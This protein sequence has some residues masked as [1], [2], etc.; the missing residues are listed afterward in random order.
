MVDDDVALLTAVAKS[1]R[2]HGARVLGAG[3]VSEA[4]R[5][6]TAGY[7]P[8]DLVLTDLRMPAASGRLILSAMRGSAPG[9]PV[10]VMTAYASET[11]REECSRLGAVAFLEKPFDIPELT[12]LIQE[13]FA[14]RHRTPALP[15]QS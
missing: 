14:K 11:T 15:P 1:L 10:I 9:V 8:V 3:G 12:R 5:L 6:L 7:G 2:L 13:V 4:I